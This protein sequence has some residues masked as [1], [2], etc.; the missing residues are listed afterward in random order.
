MTASEQD[1]CIQ[2]TETKSTEYAK[3]DRIRQCNDRFRKSL[4]DGKILLTPGILELTDDAPHEIVQKVTQ[5]DRFDDAVDPYDEHD[6]GVFDHKGQR[7]FWK[8]DYY[9]LLMHGGSSDP[10]DPFVTTRVITIML[11]SEY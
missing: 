4:I 7:I 11:A 8:I 9:D 2:N 6:M 3:R 5:Y 10:S 1:K